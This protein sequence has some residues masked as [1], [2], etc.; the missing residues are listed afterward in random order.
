MADS[1]ASELYPEIYPES[2]LLQVI[3]QKQNGGIAASVFL[4]RDPR[5]A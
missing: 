3:P 1:Q 4:F 2:R 5:E